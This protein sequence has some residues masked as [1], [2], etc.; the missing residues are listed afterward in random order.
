[1]KP[2]IRGLALDLQ[3]LDR[4]RIV[5]DRH[6]GFRSDPMLFRQTLGLVPFPDVFSGLISNGVNHDDYPTIPNSG[7]P[8]NQWG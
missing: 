5:H 3:I 4:I 7:I 1:M 8:V 6:E 2:N